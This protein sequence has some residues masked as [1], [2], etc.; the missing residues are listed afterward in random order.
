[1][2]RSVHWGVHT[3]ISSSSGAGV[4]D[5]VRGARYHGLG[6]SYLDDDRHVTHSGDHIHTGYIRVTYYTYYS[7]RFYIPLR[8]SGDA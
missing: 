6:F 5:Q 4:I 8:T 1:M 2:Y 7:T 3:G